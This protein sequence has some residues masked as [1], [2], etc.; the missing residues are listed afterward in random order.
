MPK[1][2]VDNFEELIV[3]LTKAGQIRVVH[4]SINASKPGV[5]QSR[6]STNIVLIDCGILSAPEFL[7]QEDVVDGS[8]RTL[9]EYRRDQAVW[10]A[11]QAEEPES[12]IEVPAPRLVPL[13]HLPEPLP[14]PQSQLGI[15]Q[16]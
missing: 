11:Q 10:A 1:I 15:A 9:K 13:P 8:G 5:W 12:R 16:L 4:G 6:E 3:I 7:W 2:K 14:V